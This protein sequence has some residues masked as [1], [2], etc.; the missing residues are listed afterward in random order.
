[1]VIYEVKDRNEQLLAELL[2]IWERSVR[3]THLFLSDAEVK[4][5]KEYVPVALESVEHLF[6]AGNTP[7]EPVAFMGI[8]NNRLEMLFLLPRIR[9]TGIGR[10]LLQ[11]GME[12]YHVTE[13]TVNEQNPQAI[14][15]YEHMGFVTYKRTELD[16]EGNPYP[17]LYM[18][19]AGTM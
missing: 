6:V 7:D 4:K 1:M 2:E 11:H 12:Q 17:L 9:G 15:F 10:E 8:E 19:L 3:A 5:I 14:G 13:V 18:R 16:E